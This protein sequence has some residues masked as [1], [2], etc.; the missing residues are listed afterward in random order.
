MDGTAGSTWRT[1]FLHEGWPATHVWASVR[2][3]RWKYIE[4]PVTP[5]DPASTFEPELY[6]LLNDPLELNNVAS[7]PANAQR[8]SDMAERIRELRP[9]WP[10]DSDATEEDDEE[11]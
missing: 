7:V 9:A 6:D 10:D 5:G 8:V 1:D 11:E 2:D 3:D 4:L